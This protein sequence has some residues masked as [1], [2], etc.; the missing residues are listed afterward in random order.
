VWVEGTL[1]LV[2]YK[3]IIRTSPIYHILTYFLLFAFLIKYGKLD[4]MKLFNISFLPDKSE[5]SELKEAPTLPIIA[6]QYK[7]KMLD[8][9]AA[10]DV[11]FTAEGIEKGFP[12][13]NIDR[14]L[15]IPRPLSELLIE[16]QET[17]EFIEKHNLVDNFV[18]SIPYKCLPPILYP[19]KIIALGRNY[20]AHA[21][22]HT[23]VIPTE[24]IIFS[25]SPSSII[26]NGE[27]V[28]YKKYL[29]R[30]DPEAE[31]AV[32]ISKRAKEVKEEAAMDYVAGYTCLND[33]TARDMQHEDIKQQL[34][35]FRSKSIDTFCPIGPCLLT[36]DEISG[37]PELDIQMK[38]N[39]EIRQ[40]D[41]TR[42]LLFKIPKLIAFISQ[43]M[44]LEPGDIIATGTPEGMKPV[45]PGDVMEV[46]IDKIGTLRNPVVA[47]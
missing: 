34:P 42:S 35:W 26:A 37:Q 43:Y 14:I 11:F 45:K 3:Y 28:I 29:T 8:L 19:S 5:I 25:K 27:P 9:Q 20:A 44:T 22:E 47:E 21:L 32:I 24:P 46:I 40:K 33:V 23:G 2:R 39:G 10:Y 12:F 18:I 6:I 31:L 1:A 16:F 36:A 13:H 38:V 15:S 7:N 17:L 41:N 30:V 4:T